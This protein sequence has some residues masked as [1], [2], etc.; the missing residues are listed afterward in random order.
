MSTLTLKDAHELTDELLGIAADATTAASDKHTNLAGLGAMFLARAAQS[1]VSARTLAEA[2]QNGD[3]MSV[4]RTVVEMSIDYRYIALNPQ[5]R[6]QLFDDYAHISAYKL[7]KA[8]NELLHDGKLDPQAMAII[9]QRHDDAKARRMKTLVS[10]GKG[11]HKQRI[12]E[13]WS[14]VSVRERAQAV[15]DAKV[16]PHRRMHMYKISYA[17]M[18][19]ASHSCYGSLEY[20]LVG[21]NENTAIHFGPQTPD[22]KPVDLVFV[23]MLVLT[24]DIVEINALADDKNRLTERLK[25]LDGKRLAFIGAKPA[26]PTE[27]QKPPP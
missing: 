18:C 2:G 12:Q 4:A 25:A 5:E 13:N 15:D 27:Q 7:V 23:H 14:G 19:N 10:S 8:V 11:K 26:V 1:M 17:D 24:D 16:T 6:V 20:S 21:R 22:I 3:A 9:K